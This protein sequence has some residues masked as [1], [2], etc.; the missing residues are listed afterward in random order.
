MQEI[1]LTKTTAPKA[2]PAPGQKLG[3]GHIFT[4]HMFIMN[5]TEGQGWHD[6]RI[7]PYQKIELDP[8]AMVFHASCPIR[9]FR[10]RRRRWCSTTARRCSRD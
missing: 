4:D 1:Q 9:I 10:W 3:F 2:K 7:V 8:S 5:Y 6:A